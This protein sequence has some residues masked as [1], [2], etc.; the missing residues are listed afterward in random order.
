MTHLGRR[1]WQSMVSK[2][3][4]R[5]ASMVSLVVSLLTRRRTCFTHNHG[6]RLSTGARTHPHTHTNFFSPSDTGTDPES[7]WVA[8]VIVEAEC[9][10]VAQKEEEEEEGRR[11]CSCVF[12][13]ITSS[14][15]G[16]G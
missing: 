4:G 1:H 8:I 3:E 14:Y 12:S 16:G 7:V 15:D 6:K 11:L 10:D 2:G 9:E 5:P 13:L